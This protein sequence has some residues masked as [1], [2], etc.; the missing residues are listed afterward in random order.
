MKIYPDG[1]GKYVIDFED[2][3]IDC[4]K[5]ASS[6]GSMVTFKDLFTPNVSLVKGGLFNF[7][8]KER[9]SHGAD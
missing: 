6:S 4:S 2:L 3:E 5:I 8:D 1:K 7:V 9:A